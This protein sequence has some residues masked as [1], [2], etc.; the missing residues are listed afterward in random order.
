M[1]DKTFS[2]YRVV[3]KLGGGGMGVVYKAED[4][5]L[6]RFVALKFLPEE[7][8][9]DREAL[10]RLKREARAAS[11]LDHPN[12]C[13]IHDIGEHEGQPFIVMQFLEGQTLKHLVDVG[14]RGA[15]PGEQG[16][17]RSPLPIDT[18]LD[19]AI[20][21]A[22][23]LDTAH[24]KGI[25]HRDI[26]PA[27]IFVTT[28]GQAK[29]LDFGL[30]KLAPKP[31]RV[32]EAVG[33]STLPM[34][35]LEPEPLTS[36]GEVMGT[37]A[38]MSPEQARGEE[39]DART[40]LFSF[41]AVLYEMAT[42]RQAFPGETSAFIFNAILSR[43]PTSP[44]RLNPEAPPKLEE[45]I[46]KAL[47]KDRELRYQHASDIRSDLKRLKRDT[48]SG[49][50]ASVA[51]AVMT[52]APEVSRQTAAVWAPSGPVES[53]TPSRARPLRG[54][55][56][57]AAAGVALIAL[58]GALLYF[59]RTPALT[60]RDSIVVADFV[61]TTGESVFDGTLKEALT[62]QLD[63]SP[64]LN[65]LPESRVREALRYMGRSPD[66]RVSNDVAR[67]IC[68]RAGVK[69]MLTGSIS[70]L[71]SHYVITLTAV[72]AQT[73]D[74][75]AR[76]QIE[77]ESK[78]QVL[79]A[80][81]RAASSLRRKLGESLGS[82]QRF[83]TPLEEATTSSLEAL[84]AFSLGQAEHRKMA[85]EGAM[86]HLKRAI[87][88]DPNF[89]M[90]YAT[91]GA[92]LSNLSEKGQAS[93]YLKKAFDLKERASE[94]EKLYISVH[95][96]EDATGQVDRAIEVCE[97]WKEAYPRDTVPRD[98][99]AV[100][101]TEIGQYEKALTNASE[102]MRLDAKDRFAYQNV[103]FAYQDLD[104][105]DEAKAIAEQAIAQ[106][107]DT[108]PVHEALYVIAFI[109]GDAAGVQREIA[110]GAGKPD[111]PDMLFEEGMAEYSLGKTQRAR[112]TYRRAASLAESEGLKEDAANMRAWETILEAELG[113]IQEAHQKP[114]E[115][116]TSREDKNT[117]MILAT[118]LAL[119]GDAKRAQKLIDELA[120]D[121]PLDTLL[122]NV[123][124][125][126]AR[127]I[128][129]L[130]RNSPTRAITLLEASS[131]YELGSWA[132]APSYSP[133]NTRAQAYL[134]AREGA[135]AAAEYQKILD[136]RGIDP[137]NP[138]YALARLGLGR[139]YALQGETAKARTAYQDFLAF[140]KDA[141]PDVPVL[142]EAKAEYAKLQ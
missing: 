13:T 26:K 71:G 38:Y 73:G 82:V 75:L 83:T 17:R 8:A 116:L 135:K 69:A 74:A 18:L 11:A 43:A 105:Y 25:I 60:E 5:R 66:E 111:E 40:D 53:V 91:L 63:Q 59:R 52:P 86:P 97:S 30:A 72:N 137:L 126:V 100:S 6:G 62:V 81:D 12:I 35:S 51:A 23:A 103:A 21:I 98:L 114:T 79:K 122:N 1:F 123:S 9:K 99:L 2:H 48:D 28:R 44:V 27:N 49:R 20:Q 80:L 87:E 115:A 141:D 119:C 121:F 109:R 47:E 7:L 89:A 124:L 78:E 129:E 84:N 70:S 37:V 127:A 138:V 142:K 112:E 67:E 16:E 58:V 117:R 42:G 46:N 110:W 120:K 133:I 61:N 125:P 55:V 45:I 14:A 95:Y 136:H 31:R 56:I 94:R 134:Q 57:A 29:V 65:I 130:Q 50:S 107:V 15:R 140:W 33:A 10:E 102:A 139:A 90:A 22:D 32:A 104:R 68:L 88:L 4:T 92:V 34:A 132:G 128:I 106:N 113:N 77:A 64:Y 41:G 19:L 54:W 85:E 108:L 101:Y 96:F 118:A 24:S 131:P 36:P 3:E 39:L 76:E 93:D